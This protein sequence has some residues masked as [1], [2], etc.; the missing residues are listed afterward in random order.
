VPLDQKLAEADLRAVSPFGPGIRR[1]HASSGL[2]YRDESENLVSDQQTLQRIRKLAIPPAWRDVWISPDP[3]GH[4]QATGFDRAGRKQYRYHPAWR[5]LRDR[6][7]FDTLVS[8]GNALPSIREAVNHDLLVDRLDH[9]RVLGCAVRLLD[10]GSFRIGS[11]RYAVEDD[12]HG[13]TT[14]LAREVQLDGDVIVFTYVGKEHRHQ[15]QHVVDPDARRV[16]GQ[17]L[18]RREPDQRLFAF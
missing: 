4:V 10:L 17:L 1:L 8:F 14:L 9:K 12:T 18:E 5:E 15:L 3:R 13:L 16:V 2:E 11:D 7:K 6:E